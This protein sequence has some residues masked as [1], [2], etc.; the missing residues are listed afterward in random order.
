MVQQM[1]R[2]P[3]MIQQCVRCPRRPTHVRR[4]MAM[5]GGGSAGGMPDMSA[6]A[7]MLGGGGRGRGRGSGASGSGGN[8]YS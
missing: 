5:F 6:L 3:Q 7:G 8:M 1:M 4:A 2:D